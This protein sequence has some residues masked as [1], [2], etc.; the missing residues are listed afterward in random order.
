MGRRSDLFIMNR[1]LATKKNGYSARSYLEVLEDQ[2]PIIFSPRMTFMQDNALIHKAIIIRD[3]LEG[4]G[5]PR[6]EWP[7]YSPDINLIEM[8]WGWLKD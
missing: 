6:L 2:L 4:N 1:D 3:F 5:I 7:P 8:V